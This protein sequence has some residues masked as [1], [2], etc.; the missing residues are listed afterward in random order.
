LRWMLGMGIMA[1]RTAGTVSTALE[2]ITSR[3]P[4]SLLDIGLTREKSFAVSERLAELKI[5][6]AFVTGYGEDK[7]PAAFAEAPM[8][9]KPYSPEALQALLCRF[10]LRSCGA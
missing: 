4:D 2:M 1:V 9:P 5:P 10:G 8:L 6:F 7:V 3:S